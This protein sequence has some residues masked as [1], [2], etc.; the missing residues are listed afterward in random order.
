MQGNFWVSLLAL[1]GLSHA[2]PV[3]KFL[4]IDSWWSVDYAKQACSFAKRVI[5][6][7]RD[8]INQLGCERVTGCPELMPV[9][10]ACAVGSDQEV[11]T[12]TNR[13]VSEFA[14]S[15]ECKG[16]DVAVY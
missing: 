2:E 15:P 4:V 16:I 1:F 6:G 14:S 7:D 13:F 11:V 12:F 3:N 5:E 9:V 8:L 10:A